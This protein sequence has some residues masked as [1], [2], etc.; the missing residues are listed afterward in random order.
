MYGLSPFGLNPQ[1]VIGFV[2]APAEPVGDVTTIKRWNGSDWVNCQIKLWNGS[3]W[4]DVS[5]K[6][7]NGTNFV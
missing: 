4:A 1:G 6:R 2:V 3:I 7:Y 5:V